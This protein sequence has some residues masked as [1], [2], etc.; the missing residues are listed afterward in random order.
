MVPLEF[1]KL[2]SAGMPEIHESDQVVVVD[3]QV[4]EPNDVARAH[5][6]VIS[7]CKLREPSALLWEDH[8]VFREHDSEEAFEFLDIL[9]RSFVE[10][11]LVVQ[12]RQEDGL[13]QVSFSVLCVVKVAGGTQVLLS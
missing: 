13:L 6:A 4:F 1:L 3:L 10:V 7:I 11:P 2:E 9:L 8:F 12:V 5:D